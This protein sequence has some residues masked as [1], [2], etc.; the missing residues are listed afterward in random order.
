[1]TLELYQHI[2]LNKWYISMQVLSAE[3]LEFF[4]IMKTIRM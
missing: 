1:M 3:H 2:Y 4:P